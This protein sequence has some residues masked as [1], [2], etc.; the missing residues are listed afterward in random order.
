MRRALALAAG[1]AGVLGASRALLRNA[2]STLEERWSP[3]PGDEILPEA[4]SS[5]M[6]VTIAAPPGD[7]WPWL[8]QMGCNR[9]GWYSWD[10]LDNAG[11]PSA[12]EIHAEWQSLEVGDRLPSAPSGTTWFDV[13]EV[14]HEVSLVLRASVDVR[15]RRSFDPAGKRPRLSSEGTWSFLLKSQDGATRLLVRTRG[16]MHPRPVGVLADVLFW[17]PAH[18]VMERRQLRNLK[19]LAERAPVVERE[20]VPA[21]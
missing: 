6:A 2:G 18:F 14:E 9:A 8:V 15:R 5:T 20:V 7:V 4:R 19:R 11:V 17:G 12:D 13:V 16:G 3:M 1:A 21:G 10:R